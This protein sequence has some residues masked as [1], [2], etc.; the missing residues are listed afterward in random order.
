MASCL[1][2]RS[3]S[4]R[5]SQCRERGRLR[6][7]NP[8]A[9]ES[10]AEAS[11]TGFFR[12]CARREAPPGGSRAG[13]ARRR[14]HA[15]GRL[16]AARGSR[17]ATAC[18]SLSF[19]TSASRQG[20]LRSPQ[21]PRRFASTLRPLRPVAVPPH[22]RRGVRRVRGS[23]VNQESQGNDRGQR[24]SSRGHLCP[25]PVVTPTTLETAV[26][27]E[28]NGAVTKETRRRAQDRGCPAVDPT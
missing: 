21:R 10:G 23:T 18:S 14:S 13:G 11:W 9:T 12:P 7:P 20:S 2:P 22:I 3:I 4:S 28:P 6:P 27:A 19:G 26:A 5:V 17:R 1:L 24:A 25:R 16:R 8:R 15:L